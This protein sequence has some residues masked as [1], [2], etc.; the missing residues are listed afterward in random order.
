MT[1]ASYIEIESAVSSME[2][3]EDPSIELSV[4]MPCLNE[5]DTLEA[6][7]EKA[8]RAMR[9]VAINGEIIVAD[10]GSTDGSQAIAERLGARVV[11]VKE[12]GYGSALMGGIAAARGRFIIMGDADDSY[13]FLEISK[14][15]KKLREGFD[16]V[17]GCRLPKGGG[18]V[19]PGAMPPLH[20]WWG[21]PMFSFLAR[22]WFRTP[23]HD[24]YCGLRGFKATFYNGLDQRCTGMEFATEMIIK[25]SLYRASI[26]EVPITLH[27]DGRKT[28]AP[29][30]RT[31]RDGWRTL[32]FFLMYT[33]RWLFL[34][35]GTL[36]ILL[37][38]AG[39]GLALPGIS[40]NGI[41]FDAH[42]LL[43]SSLAILCGYQSILF[44]LFTK[45]FA[46]S[47][48]L[49]P[50]DPR[51]SRFFEIVNLERG[52]LVSGGSLIIGLVLLLLAVNQWRL[53][54]FGNLD[55]SNTMRWVIPGATLTAL[56]FQTLLSSFFVSIL[57]MRR[58]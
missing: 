19:L 51:M 24:I 22:T 38:L 1:V 13:D 21:N 5:A 20:R 25:A 46:I 32:R 44:A 28:H 43:F 15:V 56:G 29:H 58:K 55:Y 8:F 17:Q 39:Y 6:C 31:F 52:L 33:P 37:G 47:E 53:T 34:A 57:G 30:L 49:L 23:I 35:P 7:I 54:G 42:T 41:N 2:R 36:L 4:V 40:V 12:K 48:G 10:N 11:S 45:T 14:F 3:G 16:L 27:P 26:A 50:E 9:E 18:R